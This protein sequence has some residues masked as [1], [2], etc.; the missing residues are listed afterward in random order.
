MHTKCYLLT[1]N[2]YSRLQCFQGRS[3]LA[4]RVPALRA[5]PQVQSARRPDDART[6]RPCPDSALLARASPTGVVV[7]VP[8]PEPGAGHGGEGDHHGAGRAAL[9]HDLPAV[10]RELCAV[11]VYLPELYQ[12]LWSMGARY[13]FFLPM[14]ADSAVVA[15]WVRLRD[16]RIRQGVWP[17]A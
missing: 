7:Q 8:G 5:R 1:V 15:L 12:G 11:L 9:A 4:A 10:L 14:L 13:A 17:P 2:H 16:G 3:H 6:P